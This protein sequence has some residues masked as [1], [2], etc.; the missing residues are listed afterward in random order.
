M[1]ADGY[2]QTKAIH[3]TD[4]R[5]YALIHAPQDPGE[6]SVGLTVFKHDSFQVHPFKPFLPGHKCA[7]VGSEQVW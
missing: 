5:Q 1:G 6:L 3:L 2:W 4:A 7:C